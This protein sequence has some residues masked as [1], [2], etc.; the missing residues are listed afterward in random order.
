VSNLISYFS[1]DAQIVVNIPGAAT[2]TLNG[3]DEI[4]EAAAG[5]YIHIA[6]L[7]VQFLD[8]TAKVGA[9]KQ[10]AEVRCTARVTTGDSKDFSV[11]EMRFQF[12]KIDGDWRITRAETVKTLQ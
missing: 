10:S 11:Q 1:T 7:N 6:A 9:D 5:G 2:G 3:R 8:A 12:Q 4:R